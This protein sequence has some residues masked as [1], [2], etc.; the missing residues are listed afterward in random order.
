MLASA[1]PSQVNHFGFT[2]RRVDYSL[3]LTDWTEEEC[4]KV[5]RS[6]ATFLRKRKTGDAALGAWRLHYAALK[7]LFLEVEVSVS[8]A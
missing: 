8:E 6:F 1:H 7:P 2:V 5:G 3:S 4:S